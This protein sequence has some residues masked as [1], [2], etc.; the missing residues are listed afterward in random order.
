M[1]VSKNVDLYSAIPWNGDISKALVSQCPAKRCVFMSRLKCSESTAG[2]CNESGSEFQT[3]GQATEK[4]RVQKVMRR[5]RGIFSLRRLAER[6]CWS[7]ETS[8]AGTQQSAKYLGAWYRRH[9][10]TVTASFTTSAVESSASA[11]HHATAVKYHA[12]VSG[13]LWSD[14]LQRSEPVAICLWLSLVQ[15]QDRV[16]IIDSR[17]DK[18][19]N[20]YL[21]WFNSRERG[22]T[23]WYHHRSF[24]PA[25]FRVKLGRI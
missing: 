9:R 17:C 13:F 7:P 6:R 14:A 12:R 5:N 21:Y 4:A 25:V 22:K 19:I 11:D 8:G 20:Q 16:A 18:Q 23:L 2:S 1:W 24:S 10:W 3:V 15:T